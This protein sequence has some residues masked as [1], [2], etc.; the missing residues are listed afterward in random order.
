M[1]KNAKESMKT[2]REMRDFCNN[3]WLGYTVHVTNSYT[4]S[5]EWPGLD[6]FVHCGQ[7]S[8]QISV[9][10]FTKN[11]K[12]LCDIWLIKRVPRWLDCFGGFV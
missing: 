4:G 1:N 5:A 12:K 3:V 7:F 11:P 9:V 6:N 8:R 10:S 2:K